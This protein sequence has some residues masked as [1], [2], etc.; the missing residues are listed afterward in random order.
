MIYDKQIL[1]ILTDVGEEGISVQ[2]LAKHVY[3]EN[4][5][6]FSAQPDFAEIHSYVQQYLLRNSKS[7]KSLIERTEKRGHYRLNASN[8]ADT[9]QMMLEFRDKKQEEPKEQ[10]SNSGDDDYS[11]SLFDW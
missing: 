1:K 5:D 7:A 9:Y 3:N 8:S 11:L 6:F 10:K 2:N 4:C